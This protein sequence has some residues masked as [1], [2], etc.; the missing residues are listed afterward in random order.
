M[1]K[2]TKKDKKI[3]KGMAKKREK[4]FKKVRGTKIIYKLL[5]AFAVPI[6]MMIF[7]GVIIYSQAAN[8]SKQKYEESAGSTIA[9]M[10]EYCDLL[11]MTAEAKSAELLI[12]TKITDYYGLNAMSK[13]ANA[14][15]KYYEIAKVA[16][17]NLETITNYISNVHMFAA[18][19]RPTSSTAND[20]SKK[21]PFTDT[22]Y[23]DFQKEEGAPFAADKTVK[24]I[25]VGKHPYIDTATEIGTDDYA[26]SFMK[27]FT[28]A[29]GFLVVDIDI[30]NIKEVLEQ[31]GFG[32]GSIVGIVTADGREIILKEEQMTGDSIFQE[33]KFYM[34]SV[35]SGEQYGEYVTYNGSD[36]LY[37]YAPIG[38][39]GM[40][41]C[42]LIPQ[43]NILGEMSNMRNLTIIFVIIAAAIALAIGL[44][45]SRSI[46]KVLNNVSRAMKS[47]A[48]GN[49]TV[50]VATNHRKDEFGI[51]AK[52]IDTM[53]SSMRSTLEEVQQFGG[54]VGISAEK[55]SETTF[56]I[57]HA[58]QEVN[59]AIAEMETS[60]IT[61]ASDAEN[62][63][64]KMVAFSKKIN[65]IYEITSVMK[66]TAND[67]IGSIG[68]GTSRVDELNRSSVATAEITQVL[69]NNIAE[70]N[71]QSS[72]IESIVNTIN[73]IAEETNL[74]SLNASIEAARAGESGR[75]FAV[76]AEAIGKLAE[77]SMSSG[78]QIRKIIENI[79]NTTFKTTESAVQAEENVKQQTAAINDTVAVF[80]EI[81]DA[82]NELV[83]KLEGVIDEMSMLAKDKDDVLNSIQAVMHVSENSVASTEEVTANINEQV[84]FI[85]RLAD[86]AMKLRNEAEKLKHKIEQFSI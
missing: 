16:T 69:V 80:T 62:G 31:A 43:V 36:F 20:S 2:R 49:L 38:E 77:Q 45:L 57:S 64:N 72:N 17:L 81:N 39:T 74:L 53:L 9:S 5:F 56:K 71:N 15:A 14:E 63:Y 6:M 58:M 55:V 21:V 29:K 59:T 75:G 42:A 66:E 46:S 22:A 83:E 82:V 52:S 25:W 84:D 19:G 37:L 48:E 60:V 50:K 85:T 54:N 28:T 13:D 26:F 10:A 40:S 86:D 51:L 18:N 12:D 7:L 33:Q 76:V 32:A 23:D 47:A 35:A 11:C 1:I 67:T 79:Q 65:N 27:K 68:K 61:Q 44:G 3:G 78:N 70:V 73:N 30:K 24:G 34:A 4:I 41:L 8:N